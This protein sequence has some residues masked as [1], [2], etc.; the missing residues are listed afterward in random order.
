LKTGYIAGLLGGAIALTG[1]NSISAQQMQADTA[2][3]SA[4]LPQLEQHQVQAYRHQDWCQNFV[5]QRGAFSNNIETSTC[6][7]FQ[8]HPQ[9]FDNQ[10]QADFETV[11]QVLTQTGVRLLYITDLEYDA[12][13]RLQGATFHLQKR[14]IRSAYVYAPGYVA[15]PADVPH[16]Q[17]HIAINADWY[18]HWEDWN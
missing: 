11:T 10:A 14:P 17:E 13:G 15:L 1:C 6:N 16:E 18:Y 4:A 5:Y 7:L 8:A 2:Q 12:A 3:L 9:P